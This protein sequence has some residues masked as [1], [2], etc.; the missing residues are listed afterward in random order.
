MLPDPGRGQDDPFG[1]LLCPVTFGGAAGNLVP[2]GAL[3]YRH[4][5]LVLA[6]EGKLAAVLQVEESGR[7][8]RPMP[9]TRTARSSRRQISVNQALSSRSMAPARMSHLPRCP[10]APMSAGLFIRTNGGSRPLPHSA[11]RGR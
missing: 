10:A 11:P 9:S 1:I 2:L 7:R 3:E 6:E 8:S 5:Q 4:A